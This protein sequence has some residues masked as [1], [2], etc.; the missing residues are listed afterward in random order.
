MYQQNK[1]HHCNQHRLTANKSGRVNFIPAR[2]F[3]SVATHSSLRLCFK[4]DVIFPTIDLLFLFVV[5]AS[6]KRSSVRGHAI[7]NCDW[8]VVNSML[9]ECLLA[10]GIP[11]LLIDSS[12]LITCRGF[13]FTQ[14]SG[15]NGR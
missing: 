15:G 9:A 2:V 4:A 7:T 14:S 11:R 3:Q 12:L 10:F 13:G 8:L 1:Y 5:A 6:T